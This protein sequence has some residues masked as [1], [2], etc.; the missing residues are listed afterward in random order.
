MQA[1]FTGQLTGED[2]HRPVDCATTAPMDSMSNRPI[3]ERLEASKIQYS[4]LAPRLGLHVPGMSTMLEF[5]DSHAK[6][7]NK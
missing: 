3:S 6:V 2:H 4:Y 7:M 5:V 1:Q